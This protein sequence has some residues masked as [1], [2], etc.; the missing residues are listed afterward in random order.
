MRKLADNIRT[1]YLT[2][3]VYLKVNMG[4]SLENCKYF[5]D[6]TEYLSLLKCCCFFK[7]P[8]SHTILPQWFFIVLP[9]TLFENL[10]KT[11]DSFP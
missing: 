5:M 9:F 10:R 2:N 3:S 4:E 8:F 11:L 7:V 6:I 1:K